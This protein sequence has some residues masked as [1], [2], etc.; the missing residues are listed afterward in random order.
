MI[1]MTREV[2]STILPFSLSLSLSLSTCVF[3]PFLCLPAQRVLLCFVCFCIFGLPAQI[4]VC[5]DVD[6]HAALLQK[7]YLCNKSLPLQ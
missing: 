5:I 4:C 7:K 2:G 1:E 3:F 6:E